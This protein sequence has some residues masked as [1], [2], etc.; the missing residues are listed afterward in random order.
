GLMGRLDLDGKPIAAAGPP[1]KSAPEI[2]IPSSDPAYY[3]SVSG[4]ADSVT[5][6][7]DPSFPQRRSPAGAVMAAIHAADGSRLLTVHGLDEMAFEIKQEDQSE[8]AKNELT[9][10]KRF[11]FVPAAHLLITIPGENDR[12][13]L[14]RLDLDEALDRAGSDDLIITSPPIVGAVAGQT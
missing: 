2:S 9:L 8:W 5:G 10:D 6:Y 3:L 14:R 11:S 13:V 12:L 4:L 7:V 1:R